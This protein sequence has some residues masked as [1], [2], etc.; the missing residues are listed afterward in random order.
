MSDFKITFARH[1]GKLK[2]EVTE[3]SVSRHEFN[4][5][6]GNEFVQTGMDTY[7][8]YE[9]SEYAATYLSIHPLRVTVGG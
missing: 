3:H 2:D 6:T 1:T 8:C 9:R 7:Q 4:R 5:I